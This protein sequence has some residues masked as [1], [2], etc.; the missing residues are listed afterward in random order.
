MLGECWVNSDLTK[1][2]IQRRAKVDSDLRCP[3]SQLRLV[4]VKGLETGLSTTLIL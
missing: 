2:Q 3:Q 4:E 1:T